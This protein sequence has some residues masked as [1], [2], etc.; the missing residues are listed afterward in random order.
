[1]VS[2]GGRGILKHSNTTTITLDSSR[3]L[4]LAN[5]FRAV[6][7]ASSA[8]SRKGGRASGDGVGVM[9]A[10]VHLCKSMLDR[11]LSA[12]ALTTAQSVMS[13]AKSTH[14]ASVMLVNLSTRG[15]S[16]CNDE[17]TR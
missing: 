10:A 9:H 15:N 5:A 1:M 17:V 6:R 11:A 16:T 7:G 14:P 12:S 8:L 4:L 13:T 2:V 3:R